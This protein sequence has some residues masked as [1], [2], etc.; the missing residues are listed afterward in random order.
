MRSFKL[1]AFGAAVALAGAARAGSEA[2]LP[3]IQVHEWGTFTVLQDE[4][5]K[6][7]GGINTD[8]EPVPSFVH[9]GPG[10][11]LQS[12]SELP[13]QS[14]LISKGWP[15]C[16]RDVLVRLETPVVYFH[17][18]PGSPPVKLD[19]EVEFHGGQLTQYYPAAKASATD[20][21][22]QSGNSANRRGIPALTSDTIGSLAWNDLTVGARSA[23][24]P[25]TSEPVWLAPRQVA[26]AD[27]RTAPSA[28]NAAGEAERYLF[29]RGVGHV[30]AP[31]SVSRDESGK[32]LLIRANL[33]AQLQHTPG[34][35]F[36]SLWLLDV[37]ADGASAMRVIESADVT[38][39]AN[40]PI[41]RT[42]AAFAPSAYSTRT[43]TRMRA[44]LH[45]ALMQQGLYSDEADALLNTWEVSYFRRPGMR[46]FFMVPPVWTEQVLPLRVSKSAIIHRAM[47]GRIELVT[48]EERR[49]LARI[50]AGPASDSKWVS[51]A[52][53]KN[54]QGRPL[55]GEGWYQQLAAGR[56]SM[57]EMNIDIPADYRAYL[58]L[59]RFRNA[60]V[61]DELDRHPTPSLRTFVSNYELGPVRAK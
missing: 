44:A 46:L 26:A 25:K 57:L 49:Q 28:K 36:G 3:P 23:A 56:R 13:A 55:Y 5:G 7:I 20:P 30:S 21:T 45:A 31:L 37:R 32:D 14:V 16:D 4:Q 8:D 9:T 10:P 34:I 39:H 61:L 2:G 54:A 33:S 24:G 42:S 6:P 17:L 41:A 50:A 35:A 15:R 47:V 58:M 11:Q 19:V 38:P 29:Y 60:L 22:G 51:G 12:N 48:P 52:L 53:R 18:P 43:V 1:L 40:Q 27:L 59:G